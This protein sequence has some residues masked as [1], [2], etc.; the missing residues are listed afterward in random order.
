MDSLLYQVNRLIDDKD[1]LVAEK[2]DNLQSHHKMWRELA[3]A[4]AEK[5]RKIENL[6]CE[7]WQRASQSEEITKR[8]D[9]EMLRVRED[10]E[11]R[12]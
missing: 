3:S 4:L 9:D 12:T 5:D 11:R 2:N 8:R 7:L 1:Q 10:Y 6:L